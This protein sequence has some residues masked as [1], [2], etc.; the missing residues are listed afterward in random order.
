MFVLRS[1]RMY[2]LH[3]PS[4]IPCDFSEVF[5]EFHLHQEHP[6]DPQPCT[7]SPL[8]V[9]LV[10]FSR[11]CH[12]FV[13]YTLVQQSDTPTVSHTGHTSQNLTSSGPLYRCLPSTPV[14]QSPNH[15]TLVFSCS[16]WH[17]ITI[18]VVKDGH[19]STHLLL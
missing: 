1:G 17:Q 12:S 4:P 15:F 9:R 2:L 14:P 3:Y 18:K 5:F 16:G 19:S 11:M 6:T 7:S 10:L 8:P 13:P